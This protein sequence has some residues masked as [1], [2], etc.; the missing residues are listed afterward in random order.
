[1]G[2][3][4]NEIYA[5]QNHEGYFYSM[6]LYTCTCRFYNWSYCIHVY[7]FWIW[8]VDYLT[9]PPPKKKKKKKKIH[10]TGKLGNAWP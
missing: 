1:M 10:D 4:F 7:V 5:K 9:P 3:I 2:S 6:T 8:C